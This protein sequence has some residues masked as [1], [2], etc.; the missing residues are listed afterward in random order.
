VFLTSDQVHEQVAGHG[1]LLLLDLLAV[2]ELLDLLG[3]HDDL[4]DAVLL[5]ERDAAVLKVLLDLVLVS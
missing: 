5:P 3:G 2:L 1:P 4:A